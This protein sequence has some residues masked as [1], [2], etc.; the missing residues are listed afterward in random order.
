MSEKLNAEVGE[1]E[2][3]GLL[4]MGA[5]YNS[6]NTTIAP[7]VGYGHHDTYGEHDANQV[8]IKGNSTLSMN[9]RLHILTVYIYLYSCKG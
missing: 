3:S 5:A 8:D 4:P 1:T 6:S 9:T 7:P 2:N